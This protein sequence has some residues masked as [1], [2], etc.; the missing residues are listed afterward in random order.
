MIDALV[1]LVAICIL[2]Y[3]ILFKRGKWGA[4]KPAV[5][6]IDLNDLIGRGPKDPERDGIYS[7]ST[8]NHNLMTHIGHGFFHP[9]QTE[10]MINGATSLKGELFRKVPGKYG[11]DPSNDIL[12]AWCYFY[13][14]C[15]L[16]CSYLVKDVADKWWRSCLNLLN[17]DGKQSDRCANAG[18]IWG[19]PN[20]WMGL[21]KPTIGSSYLSGAA[22]LALAARE[23][24]G[25]WKFRYYMFKLLSFGWFWER[26]PWMPTAKHPFGY[27]GHVCQM[28]LYV[29]HKCGHNMEPG[30]RWIAVDNAP[31][32]GIQPFIGGMAAECGVLTAKEKA[33]AL[34]WLLAQATEWPQ[35]FHISKKKDF[36]LW[37]MMAHAAVQLTGRD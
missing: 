22:L 19:C 7:D 2:P 13:V 28:C 29:I 31:R 21:S 15:N 12:A 6:N 4:K 3:F 32:Q 16:K 20:S 11:L 27:V 34:E 18:V 24:G 17:K 37:S 1:V 36:K 26:F 23:L 30:L 14:V 35:H 8:D 33:N 5:K 9:G 25:K 10:L